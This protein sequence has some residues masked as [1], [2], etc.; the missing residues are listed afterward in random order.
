M[1]QPNAAPDN[2]SGAATAAPPQPREARRPTVLIVDDDQDLVRL[3]EAILRSLEVEIQTA[4]TGRSAIQRVL[5]RPPDLVL[6]DM[7]LP[8]LGGLEVLDYLS[9]SGV[10]AT[11]VVMTADASVSLAVEAMRKGALDYLTKP[12]DGERLRSVVRSALRRQAFL[13]TLGRE[14]EPGELARFHGLL[15]GSPAMRR[16]YRLLR[17]SAPGNAPAWVVGEA[18]TELELTVRALHAESDRAEC[19]LQ[20][21]DASQ[22]ATPEV[23]HRTLLGD[24]AQPGL[25]E[26]ARGGTLCLLEVQRLSPELQAQLGVM[27]ASTPATGWRL[28]AT[29]TLATGQ[30]PGELPLDAVLAKALGVLTIPL[31]PL[32]DRGEDILALA[33][34]YLRFFGSETG[35]HFAA[36]SDEAQTGLLG[37]HWP[38]NVAE[39]REKMRHVANNHAGGIV[40]VGMFGELAA[41]TRVARRRKAPSNAADQA[42]RKVIEPLWKL[43]RDTIQKALALCEGSVVEAARMLEISPAALYRKMRLHESLER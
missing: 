11:V 35:K 34:Y 17:Q 3:L 22:L 36:L 29:A 2:A 31:P 37:Y 19:V 8:D 13:Q 40:G 21:L 7:R 10:M 18:G 42:A 1:N 38:G 32:R 41:G 15:G 43:E 25:L 14:D 5:D 9:T 26:A 12:L 30:L 24:A 23:Q 4:N 39:L 27:L 20:V 16:L 28:L 33:L 6:L